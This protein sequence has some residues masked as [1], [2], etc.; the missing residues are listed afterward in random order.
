MWPSQ[1]ALVVD[2]QVPERRVSPTASRWRSSVRAWASAPLA[3][4]RAASISPMPICEV[5]GDVDARGQLE[6]HAVAPRAEVVEPADD[7]VLPATEPIG[8]ERG[9]EAVVAERHHRDLAPRLAPDADPQRRGG[10]VVAVGEHVGRT[11]TGSSIVAFA[12]KSP[13][14]TSGRDG[15]HDDTTG[16]RARQ[17]GRGRGRHRWEP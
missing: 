15:F 16:P 9:R 10:A 5:D 2:G 6:L 17:G 4:A 13:P 14:S 12:G 1:V 11:V 7:L 3:P 8:H